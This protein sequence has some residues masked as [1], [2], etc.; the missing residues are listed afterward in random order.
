MKSLIPLLLATV[1]IAYPAMVY[2]GVQHI[3]P[4]VFA[5]ILFSL[6]VARFMSTRHQSGKSQLLL[7][8]VVTIY[9]VCLMVSNSDDWLKLYPVIIS[10]CLAAL[11]ALSLKHSETILERLA[12]LGGAEIT[13]KAKSYIRALT[14]V[15]VLLLSANGL[16]ALYLAL[17]ASLETWALYCGLLSYVFFGAFF[18]L[19]YTYRCYYIRKH[20]EPDIPMTDTT[21]L[22]SLR[23]RFASSQWPRIDNMNTRNNQFTIDLYIN[24]DMHWLEGHFPEQPVVA[25]V[26][27]THWAA[28]FAKQLFNTGDEFV[29]IDNLKFQQVI[30]PNQNLQLTLE[31]S[32]AT[33][34]DEIKNSTIRFRYSRN[35]IIFSEGKLAFRQTATA[36][37]IA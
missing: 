4:A 8:L 35:E 34:R 18:A 19:E 29:R 17:F 31:R 9:C 21:L 36:T 7:L 30:L 25:G 23:N 13:P 26:V 20:R 11:F 16:I 22:A 3:S 33:E 27:Q 5:V 6:A 1:S 14:Q 37:K 28:E 12:R 15:W 24:K 10:W 2:F 32:E